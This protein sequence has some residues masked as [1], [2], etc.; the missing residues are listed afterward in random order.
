M[1]CVLG[2][3]VTVY[4]ADRPGLE[5][6]K[7]APRGIPCYHLGLGFMRGFKGWLCYDPAGKKL[8]CTRDALF[9][10]TF[11]PAR[12]HDQRLL[13]HYDFTPRTQM[14]EQLHGSMEEAEAAQIRTLEVPWENIMETLDIDSEMTDAASA[15][16][17]ALS[18]EDSDLEHPEAAPFVKS[19]TQLQLKSTQ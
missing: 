1:L 12:T 13:S 7:M 2:C 19:G 11:M 6:H 16:T 18:S 10:E 9:D 4:V 3:R 14:A 17:S 5:H 15:D 8:F